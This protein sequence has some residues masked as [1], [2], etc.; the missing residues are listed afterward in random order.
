[1]D[2]DGDGRAEWLEE[3]PTGKVVAWRGDLSGPIWSAHAP[4]HVA[5]NPIDV[6]AA[7]PNRAASLVR[8]SIVVSFRPG[9]DRR[10]DVSI[11]I[12]DGGTGRTVLSGHYRPVG[13][14]FPVPEWLSP[15]TSGRYV[16]RDQPSRLTECRSVWQA[17]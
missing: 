13:S 10:I 9:E 11:W 15:V 12:L 3:S 6:V 14:G 1:V 7:G 8:R 4:A 16:L 2:L 17:D 5:F